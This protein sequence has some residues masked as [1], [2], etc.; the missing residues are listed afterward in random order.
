MNAPSTMSFAVWVK[1]DTDT[2]EA[3]LAPGNNSPTS[4]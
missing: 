1:V 3:A 2:A 4:S